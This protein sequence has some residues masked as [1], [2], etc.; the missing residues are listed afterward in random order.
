MQRTGKSIYQHIGEAQ[1]I[2][3]QLRWLIIQI[4]WWYHKVEHPKTFGE[5][6]KLFGIWMDPE[7]KEHEKYMD[8]VNI[9]NEV[10]KDDYIKELYK[11]IRTM[12]GLITH[13]FCD[14]EL[15]S[16][17]SKTEF[18]EFESLPIISCSK[19]SNAEA[20]D[21]IFLFTFNYYCLKLYNLLAD[22]IAK[23]INKNYDKFRYD[24]NLT[25]G[26]VTRVLHYRWD[27]DKIYSQKFNE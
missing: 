17:H 26:N 7:Y 1:S 21:E 10:I 15:F 11:H 8:T 3:N 23:H 4:G 12:R 13:F 19:K 24:L 25:R 18:F 2:F 5:K 16:L 22:F 27:F 9:I 20:I 14:A 6:W